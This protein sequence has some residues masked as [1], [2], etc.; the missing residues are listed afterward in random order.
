MKVTFFIK[1]PPNFGFKLS[2]LRGWERNDVPKI[3]SRI[4]IDQLL[5]L[6]RWYIYFFQPPKLLDCQV[7]ARCSPFDSAQGDGNSAQSQRN[8]VV[9]SG[10]EAKQQRVN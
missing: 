9:L 6:K 4:F 7:L 1:N 10:V 3:V 5:S 8:E 2:E